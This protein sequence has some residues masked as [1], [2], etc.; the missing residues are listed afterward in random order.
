MSISDP[1]PAPDGAPK[2]IDRRES[3]RRAAGVLALGL[4]APS[5]VVAAEFDASPD[6]DYR[7]AFYGRDGVPLANVEIPERVARTLAEATVF[8]FKLRFSERSLVT[9]RLEKLEG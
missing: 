2:P 3:L 8:M 9:Y 4:G 7:I 1:S 5:S 6:L